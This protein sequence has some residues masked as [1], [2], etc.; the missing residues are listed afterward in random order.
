MFDKTY[1]KI[2]ETELCSLGSRK[3]IFLQC[4]FL[5]INTTEVHCILSTMFQ[6]FASDVSIKVQL[7]LWATEPQSPYSPEGFSGS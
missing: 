2:S 7:E 6:G 5:H 1:E 3:A 4:L